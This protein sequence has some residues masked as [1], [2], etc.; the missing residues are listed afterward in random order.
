MILH[1]LLYLLYYYRIF[2]YSMFFTRE[3]LNTVVF[4]CEANSSCFVNNWVD[5]LHTIAT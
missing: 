3:H 2:Y 5:K 4:Q 1:D